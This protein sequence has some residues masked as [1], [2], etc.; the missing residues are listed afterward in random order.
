VRAAELQ[1]EDLKGGNGKRTGRG[2]TGLCRSSGELLCFGAPR[3]AGG[4]SPLPSHPSTVQEEA[5]V[6]MLRLCLS[7]PFYCHR[8]T[9]KKYR[10]DIYEPSNRSVWLRAGCVSSTS[11]VRKH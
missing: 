3:G 4:T 1:E 10:G 7:L 9:E 8:L 6:R 11:T 2:S 5:E